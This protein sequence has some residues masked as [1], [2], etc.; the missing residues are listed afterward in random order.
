MKTK[1][2][3]NLLLKVLSVAAAVILWLVVVNI[4]DAVG[5]RP[6]RNVKVSMVNMEALT[7]Q[8]QMCRI[9]EGTDV[10]DLTVYARRSVLNN[11]K[12]SDFVVTADMQK[13]LQYGSMVKIEVSYVGDATIE[14]VEQNR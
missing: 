14:R 13:D 11:L 8:G 3:D 4:D 12:S 6:I 10:V 5:S 1:V 7:S 2:F 9:E